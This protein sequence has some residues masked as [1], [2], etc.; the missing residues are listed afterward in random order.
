MIRDL[1]QDVELLSS[2]P[3]DEVIPVGA[4]MQAGI[5]VG[6]ESLALGEDSITVDSCATDILVK[7]NKK[8]LCEMTVSTTAGCN[9]RPRP[10]PISPL[11][12]NT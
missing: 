8:A 4:A 12:P 11:A 9:S 1:F 7:V 10:C 2:I 5:L 3:P 6:K